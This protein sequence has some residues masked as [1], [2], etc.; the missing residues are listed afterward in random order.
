MAFL[1][2]AQFPAYSMSSL[3]FPFLLFSFCYF[4]YIACDKVEERE[5]GHDRSIDDS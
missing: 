1:E 4:L 2:P 3:Y 5:M